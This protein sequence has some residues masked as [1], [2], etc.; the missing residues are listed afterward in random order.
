MVK[1]E[2]ELAATLCGRWM[3]PVSTPVEPFSLSPAG[4]DPLVRCHVVAPTPPPAWKV[5]EKAWPKAADD[6]TRT[7]V[8]MVNPAAA[9]VKD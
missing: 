2:F 7:G 1:I 3:V 4:R 8:V 5:N 6:G 9:T